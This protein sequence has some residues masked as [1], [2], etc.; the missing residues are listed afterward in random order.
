MKK[1]VQVL[2]LNL[3]TSFTYKGNF[4]L[5]TLIDIFRVVAEISFWKILFSNIQGNEISGYNFDSIIAYYIFM[6][7]IGSFTNVGSIGYKVANDI[8]EG[9]LNNLL[10]RPINYIGYCFTETISQR[11]INLLI[12]LLMFIPVIIFGSGNFSLGITPEQL[13]LLP[14]VILF[15]FILSFF[16][17]III[18][19]L[20]F[21]ITEVT[22]F[23]FLKDVI[24]DFASGRVFPLDLFPISLF[25]VF[26]FLPFMYCTFFPVVMLTKGI[27]SIGLYQGL[28]IQL[29]WIV[30]LYLLIKVLWRFGLK[31]YVGTGA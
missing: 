2:K 16:I 8:K 18:S 4:L 27:S 22:S 21:W 13:Y 25:S 7:I 19:L 6:F 1:Y 29:T 9:A 3:Q 15:S 5:T 30:L 14:I 10:V 11:L 26:S 23:F 31:K 20:V 17:N 24:L 12:A 28:L